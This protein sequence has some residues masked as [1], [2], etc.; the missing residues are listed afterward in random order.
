MKKIFFILLIFALAGCSDDFLDRGSLTQLAEGNFWNTEQ[1]ALLGLHGI[2]DVLQSN[3]MYGG[4]LNAQIGLPNHD[5][6]ADNLFNNYKW[7]GAGNFVEGR[8]DPSFGYFE[9]FWAANYRGIARANAAIT[10]IGKMTEEN[11]PQEKKNGLIAQ[12]R[13]LRA[14]FYVNLAVY[15]EEVPL[16]VEV[17]TLDNAYVPKNSY[18]EIAAQIV[19]DLEFAAEYLPP[20]YDA[21]LLGYATKGAALGLLARF[22]LYNKNYADVIEATEEIMTLGY[23]LYPNYEQLFTE[24]G[25]LSDEI[26]FSVRFVMDQSDN[27]ETFSASYVGIPKVNM[28]PM[29]NLINSYYCTDGL[30]ITESGLYEAATPKLNRDPR[31]AASV[32][33]QGDIFM[34]HLNRP[35]AG[36]TATK[37]GLKKY[38]R[39]NESPDGIG[40]ASPGGQDFYVIRYADVLLM[41]A[42]ALAES[43]EDLDEVYALVNEV[44]GRVGMPHIEDVEGT[45]L[46]QQELI[47]IVRHERRVELAF[48]G[49][50]FFDVKR[51][52]EVEQA[53]QRALDDNIGPYK[54]VYKGK[55]SEVFPI[56]L[57]ELDANRNLVQHP[58]W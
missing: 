27:D 50:R 21:E 9:A 8:T 28:Q 23:G 42:E 35:F 46:S 29:P 43:G 45:G 41:R 24:A 34:K 53:Y 13:F 48:E 32:Y 5:A 4:N 39:D 19:K 44:R 58:A 36:N 1:D 18:D 10:N 26:V 30:P 14:L 47:D 6:F 12:A 20:A 37:Y 2:Y 15:Y 56:P 52:D 49:L 38:V 17:Q 54:P 22:Q 51:W 7:E 55:M 40:P 3:V 16:I 57:G 11:V 31:L 33:F 25:E